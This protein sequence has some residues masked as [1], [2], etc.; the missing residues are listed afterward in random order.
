MQ[1]ERLENMFSYHP[2]SGEQPGLYG[3]VRASCLELAL[4]IDALVP[5]S[6]EKEQAFLRLNEAMFWANGAIARNEH[7]AEN[8][9]T[10]PTV[11]TPTPL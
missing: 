4:F 9:T 1:K 3:A 2:A 11:L 5:D 6:L 7:G 8:Q 10:V